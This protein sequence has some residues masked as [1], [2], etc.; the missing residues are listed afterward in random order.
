MGARVDIID[1]RFDLV[2][3]KMAAEKLAAQQQE[4]MKTQHEQA[5]QVPSSRPIRCRCRCSRWSTR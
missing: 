2:T 1:G 4:H 5:T 3:G